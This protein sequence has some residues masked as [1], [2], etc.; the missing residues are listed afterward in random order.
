MTALEDTCNGDNLIGEVYGPSDSDSNEDSNIQENEQK[1]VAEERV[2]K[3]RYP[4][5][6]YSIK[7]KVFCTNLS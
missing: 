7:G 3:R 6:K 1:E 2:K 5:Y 4:A